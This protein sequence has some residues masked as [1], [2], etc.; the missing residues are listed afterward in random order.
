MTSASCFMVIFDE[1]II[2]E[3]YHSGGFGGDMPLIKYQRKSKTGKSLEMH[4]NFIWNHKGTLTPD[5]AI[6]D[7]KSSTCA[8]YKDENQAYRSWL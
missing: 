7:L 5:T 6:H 2:V 8:E 1:Y 3:Q 4:F